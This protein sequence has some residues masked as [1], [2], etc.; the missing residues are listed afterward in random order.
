MIKVIKNTRKNEC[1]SACAKVKVEGM[2]M[3]DI[4]VSTTGQGFTVI[5]LCPECMKKLRKSL[6]NLI[7]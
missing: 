1:C 5:T 6:L 7:L 4:K 2:I 3:H